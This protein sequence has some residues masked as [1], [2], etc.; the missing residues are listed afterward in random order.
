MYRGHKPTVAKL[1]TLNWLT[2]FFYISLSVLH[3]KYVW[4]KGAGHNEISICKAKKS[5]YTPWWRLEGRGGIAPTHSWPRHYMGVSGQRHALAPLW[6]G[7]RTPGTHCTEGGWVSQSE[8]VWTQRLEENSLPL[9]GIEPQ[10]P[11]R[12]LRSQILYWLS[13]PSSW[14]KYLHPILIHVSLLSKY[15]SRL[16]KS[17]VCPSVSLWVSWVTH[18]GPRRRTR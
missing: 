15:E 4:Q 11:G 14:D 7:E 12:P 8:P 9:P 17:P 5:R 3:I 6:P 1:I 18:E 2:N 13:Y 10:S 16:I